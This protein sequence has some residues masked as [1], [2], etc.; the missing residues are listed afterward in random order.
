[1]PVCS[2]HFEVLKT[3]W[4]PDTDANYVC[5]TRRRKPGICTNAMALPMEET[6]DIILSVIEGEVLSPNFVEEM[7]ALIDNTP[8][9]RAQLAAE[10]DALRAEVSRLV[11]A[12]AAGV[13]RA[14][15]AEDIRQ[16]EAKIRSLE[17]RLRQPLPA[18]PN[19]AKLRDALLQRTATWRVDLR[20]EPHMARLLLRRLMGPL[21]LHDDSE[22]PEWCRGQAE[23]RPEGLF[24]GLY[25]WMA[26][27]TGLQRLY[28][29]GPLPESA[30]W[31]VRP[32]PRTC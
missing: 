19:V 9:E 15:V 25:N 10:C 17:G 3:P 14:T 22:R 31:K 27:P 12:I 30:R 28:V 20:G 6:D 8:D 5:S 2:G 18:P 11:N 32:L 23:T 29:S 4:K 7:L 13:A 24:D 1:M 21:T 26:S 16:R